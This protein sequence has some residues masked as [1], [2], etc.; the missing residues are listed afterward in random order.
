MSDASAVVTLK[1][2]EDKRIRSGHLWIFSNEIES[3]EGS[4]TAGDTVYVHDASGRF[5]GTG[6]MNPHSLIAVRLVSR[7]RVSIDVPFVSK[8][9]SD[10]ISLRE[11]LF[12]GERVWRAVYSEADL[13]PGLVVDRYDETVV[14]QSLTAGMERRLDAVVEALEDRLH[15]GTVVL[16][17]DSPMRRY[18][19]L[20]EEKRVLKGTVNDPVEI[21]QDRLRFL[22]DVLNGQKTGFF[23]DQRENR[24]AT[25][26]LAEGQDVLD[27]CCYTGAWSVY[28]AS[29]GAASVTGVDSSAA[30][31]DLAA[32]NLQLNAPGVESRF[33]KG[34]VFKEMA[35]MRRAGREYGL[36]VLDPPSFA[37]SRKKIREAL[38]AYRALNRL[39]L[40][41]MKPGGHLVTCTC[42]HLVERDAFMNALVD[43]AR[44]AGRRARVIGVRGQSMDHP[45]ILGLPETAYL[46]CAILEII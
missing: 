24:R 29:A 43:A 30:A 28:A 34:D 9:V 33:M 21:E 15:P 18:E 20:P 40:S 23:L 10:A 12:P 22:V 3:V 19:E 38:K 16:R 44:E 2:R 14:I 5:L 1:K 17:N 32:R 37:R 8:R 31:V 45:V 27:C 46:T 25:A 6:Y 11:R 7:S 13:L 42:S 26:R 39:A 36:V 35:G 4:V 41:L